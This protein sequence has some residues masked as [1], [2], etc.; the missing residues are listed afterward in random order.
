MMHG[1]HNVKLTINLILGGSLQKT[2]TDDGKVYDLFSTLPPLF[3]PFFFMNAYR[4][5]TKPFFLF[6]SY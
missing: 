6:S 5:I 2:L 3:F 4:F 1:T